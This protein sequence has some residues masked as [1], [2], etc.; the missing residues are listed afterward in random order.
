MC[1]PA[2]LCERC[3]GEKEPFDPKPDVSEWVRWKLTDESWAKWRAENPDE[4]ERLTQRLAEKRVDRAVQVTKVIGSSTLTC[5]D[6]VVK[7]VTEEV[8]RRV[9]RKMQSQMEGQ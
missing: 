4:V 6:G 8:S 2:Q 3:A 1:E 9:A 7:D 5:P